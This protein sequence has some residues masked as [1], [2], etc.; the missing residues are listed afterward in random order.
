MMLRSDNT[1]LCSCVSR[2]F[3]GE[4][5]IEPVNLHICI[6][7]QRVN[8]CFMD[9]NPGFVK[10]PPYNIIHPRLCT[11]TWRQ[12]CYVYEMG[13]VSV[14]SSTN[15]YTVLWCSSKEPTSETNNIIMVPKRISLYTNR[16]FLVLKNA[17]VASLLRNFEWIN[18]SNRPI[19][20]LSNGEFFSYSM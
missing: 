5:I 2:N 4:D 16:A 3:S 6:C 7:W 18:R 12:K 1:R 11:R 13:Q 9:W 20:W 19:R 17:D 14:L 15:K 10:R 8:G